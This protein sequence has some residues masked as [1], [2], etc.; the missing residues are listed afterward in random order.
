MATGNR[1][2]VILPVGWYNLDVVSY[3]VE[4]WLGI[5]QTIYLNSAGGMRLPKR[6]REV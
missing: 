5:P 1:R 3:R 4:L 6:E 2:G